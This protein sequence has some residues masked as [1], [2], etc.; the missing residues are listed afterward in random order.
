MF[1]LKKIKHYKES[2]ITIDGCVPM[3]A[4]ANML[5]EKIK[6]KGAIAYGVVNGGE[7]ILMTMNMNILTEQESEVIEKELRMLEQYFGETNYQTIHYRMHK[8]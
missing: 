5:K 3:K 8:Q 2:S 6:T 4:I 7:N 1:N